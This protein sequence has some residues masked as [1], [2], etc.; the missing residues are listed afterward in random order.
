MLVSAATDNEEATAQLARRR[1][2]L[3]STRTRRSNAANQGAREWHSDNHV[4]GAARAPLH[5]L[6]R[7][8]VLQNAV[9]PYWPR[10]QLNGASY[11]MLWGAATDNEKLTACQAR[12]RRS[13]RVTRTPMSNAA[14]QRALRPTTKNKRRCASAPLHWLVRHR[15]LQHAAAPY[16]RAFKNRAASYA[17]IRGA[18]THHDEATTSQRGG[19]RTLRV[20]RTPMSNVAISGRGRH[21]EFMRAVRFALRCIGLLDSASFSTP[22][23]P[24]SRAF[25]SSSESYAMTLSAATHGEEATASPVRRR[26]YTGRNPYA[27]SNPANQR[28]LGLTA[29]NVSGCESAPLHWLVR[30]GVLQNAAA[31]HRPRLHLSSRILL[32]ASERGKPLQ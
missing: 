23:H 12:R 14:N 18:A 6:V 25:N 31:P 10:L 1:R 21:H 22:P 8:R 28:A 20:T 11:A 4:N 26:P 15:V 2:S 5:W 27:L 32:A 3:E 16:G 24:S 7:Q 30:H 17:L 9:A 29:R 19:V 13:L